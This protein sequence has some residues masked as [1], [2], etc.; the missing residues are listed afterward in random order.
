MGTGAG[1]QAANPEIIRKPDNSYRLYYSVYNGTFYYLA[2]KDTTDT[3]APGSTNLGL[4]QILA[5]GTSSSDQGIAPEIVQTL[6]GYRL[7][8][9]YNGS[10]WQLAF[11]GTID[12]SL[13]YYAGSCCNWIILTVD[14]GGVD[15]VGAFSSVALDTAG[16][17]FITYYY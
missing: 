1:D 2:Y 17:P 4:R 9:S 3:N 7:Y 6:A 5:T 12:A 11:K 16:N 15:D 13:P 10:Y 8:Y 14:G